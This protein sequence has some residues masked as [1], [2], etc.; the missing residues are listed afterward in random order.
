[1]GLLSEEGFDR[2][3]TDAEDRWRG[4]SGPGKD[5]AVRPTANPSG[6]TRLQ[7]DRYDC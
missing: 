5:L 7:D 4:I 2:G 6:D 1:M 3:W